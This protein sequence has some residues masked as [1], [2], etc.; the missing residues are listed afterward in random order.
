MTTAGVRRAERIIVTG[1]VQG[2]GFRPFVYRLANE[3]DL[4]G[5]VGNDSSRVFIAVAGI[6][7]RISELV[8]RLVT[9]AP[10][11]AIIERVEREPTTE[12]IEPGFRIVDSRRAAGERTLVAPDTAVCDDCVSEM[13]DP[14]DRRYEHPFITCTNC[15]PRFT[16]IRELPYDRPNTTMVDFDMCAA[17]ADEYGD[18]ANRR[19]HAQPIG[20]HDCGPRVSFIGSGPADDPIGATAAELRAGHIV[21]IKGIGGFHLACDARDS[22]AIARLRGRKNRPDKPLAIMVRDV[23]AAR[24]LAVISDAEAAQLTSPARPVVLL[25]ARPDNG[26]SG[27]V[28][29]GNPLVGIMLP[30]TPVHHLLFDRLDAIDALVMTS[31]NT[32]GEPIVHRDDDAADVLAPLCD[33][34]LTHDRAIHAPC[35]DSVVRVVRDVL[36]P[37]RR[38]RGYAPIPVPIVDGARTVLATGGELKNTFCVGSADH[39]WVSPHLGDMENLETLRLFEETIARFERFYDVDPEVVAIDAHPGYLTSGWAR[40][41]R[42]DRVVEVQH[43]HAHVAA[44]MA[45]HELD[46]HQ[47]VLGFA[48]D[49]TGYGSDG[50]IWGGEVLVATADGFERVGHLAP[51][52]LPGGDAAVRHPYRVALAHLAAADVGWADDLAPVAAATDV[53][54]NLLRRQL[55]TG[56]ACVPTTSMGRLFDAVASMLDLRHHIT[57]EAQAAIDLEIAAAGAH[58]AAVRSTT[59]GFDVD[60]A[61]IDGA[62][63]LRA[64]VADVRSGA[65]AAVVA[66]RFHEAVA[67]VVLGVVERLRPGPD[68]PIVLSGGVFQNALLTDLCIERLAATGIT[69]LTHHIVPPNDGGLALGQVFIATHS[70]R[71][72]T[73]ET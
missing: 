57:Y 72:P 27:L 52:Q 69:P 32:S 3:L 68:V 1:V 18:P 64:I 25:R 21:T 39:A 4:D 5:V 70:N 51:I 13:R 45:E 56:F 16:I 47:P 43:H 33:A 22:D 36:L 30:Y 20:C 63:V 14:T 73:Q 37:V 67:D 12:T 7:D 46:P 42:S 41:H 10:P 23:A 19:Y 65:D 50:T 8:D 58:L 24:R 2:V 35:D 59:Y 44:V 28:A 34:M 31:G 26:L 38:A 48:F 71:R 17:C 40:S 29:P 9:D 15:G 53:E 55:D 49:G 66:R 11:L 62:P 54:R 60:G 6:P 61:R